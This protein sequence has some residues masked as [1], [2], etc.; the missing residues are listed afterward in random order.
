MTLLLTTMLLLVTA[1]ATVKLQV[2]RA[3]PSGQN[4]DHI[5]KNSKILIEATHMQRTSGRAQRNETHLNNIRTVVCAIVK[6]EDLYV[7]EWIHYNKFLGFD[8]IQIYDNSDQG[9]AKIAYLPSVY[10][11]LVRVLHFPGKEKQKIAYADCGKRYSKEQFW[12][13]FVDCDE[14]IVLRKHNT[15]QELLYDMIPNGGALSLFRV[16]FGSNHHTHYHNKPVLSRFTKRKN[17]TDNYTKT[18]SYLPDTIHYGVHS[19]IVRNT[20]RRIDCHGNALQH[21]FKNYTPHEDV[22]TVFHYSTKSFD[23]FRLKRLRGDADVLKRGSRYHTNEGEQ[24]IVK[25][26]EKFDR[27]ANAVTETTTLDFYQRKKAEMTNFPA[28]SV[29]LSEGNE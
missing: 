18:I 26:F 8:H 28:P 1:T 9:S 5:P 27:F 13:A 29:F 17:S 23:E 16:F 11:D 2:K 6:D 4:V 15:I 21:G 19:T 10:G 3:Q 20:S 22:A 25:E 7:D 12:A 24:L 14:F